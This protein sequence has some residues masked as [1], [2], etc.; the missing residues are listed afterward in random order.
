[1]RPNFKNIPYN[2]AFQPSNSSAPVGTPW[3]TPEQISVN[4]VY[5]AKDLENMEH[6]NYAAGL[7]RFCVVLTLRC[8]S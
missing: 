7:P 6:L 8:T 5:S 2:P 4:P 3:L 1:M